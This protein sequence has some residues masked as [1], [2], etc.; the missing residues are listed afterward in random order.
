MAMNAACAALDDGGVWCW[1]GYRWA[2]TPNAAWVVPERRPQRLIA[3]E[4]RDLAVDDHEVC[5][6]D[7]AA[8]ACHAFQPE[9]AAGDGRPVDERTPHDGTV[10]RLATSR[11][12]LTARGRVLCWDAAAAAPRDLARD[13]VG[14][15]VVTVAEGRAGAACAVTSDGQTLCW[16]QM[17]LL[18]L[19]PRPLPGLTAQSL[20]LPPH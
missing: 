11:C 20:A 19:L 8:I 2:S 12:G 14:P 7:G 6:L 9:A 15:G 16:G 10:T 1:G 18:P 4:A 5:A 17:G 13:G 3:A